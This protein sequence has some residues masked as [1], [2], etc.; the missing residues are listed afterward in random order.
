VARRVRWTLTASA[1]L[2]E[3]AAFI[4]ED[5]PTA[6]QRVVRRLVAAAESLAALAERGRQVPELEAHDVRELLAGNYRV[7]YRTEREATTILVIVH[8]ARDLEALW[9]RRN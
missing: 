7:I 1:D 9:E 8:G 6:A 5:N 3:I 4:A 2:E